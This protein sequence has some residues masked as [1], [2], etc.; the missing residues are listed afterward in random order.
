MIFRIKSLLL[1]AVLLGSVPAAQ[2]GQTIVWG[3]EIDS[4]NRASDGSTLWGNG[5]W[6]GPVI[7]ALGVFDAGFIPSEANVADWADNWTEFHRAPTYQNGQFTGQ[8]VLNDNSV[9]AAGQQAYMWVY[10]SQEAV[11]GSE[12]LLV[13]DDSADGNSADDWVFQAIPADNQ[14]QLRTLNWDLISTDGASAGDGSTVIFGGVNQPNSIPNSHIGG[15][16]TEPVAP[17]AW[18]LQTHTFA[19][20]PEPSVLLLAGAGLLLTGRRRR[21]A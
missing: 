2:A 4:I 14:Q 18:C 20:I 15:E 1:S 7:A 3:N 9:F 16:W 13:T 21:Q 6:A 10:N 8:A 19:A 17:A 5:S 12:W 11:H